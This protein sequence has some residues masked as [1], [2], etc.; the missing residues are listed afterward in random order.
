MAENAGT[1]SN[2][3]GRM[4][5][6]K[7]QIVEIC[8][9]TCLTNDHFEADNDYVTKIPYGFIKG[10][11][12]FPEQYRGLLQFFTKKLKKNIKDHIHASVSWVW[13]HSKI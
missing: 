3:T 11:D 4:L 12:K 2:A 9:P 8:I 6:G 10:L 5:S 13:L 1:I 7:N